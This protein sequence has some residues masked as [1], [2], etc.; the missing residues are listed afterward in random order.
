MVGPAGCLALAT[1]VRCDGLDRIGAMN[2]Q[3]ERLVVLAGRAP[4]GDEVLGPWGARGRVAVPVA[5]LS[6]PGMVDLGQDRLESGLCP[7][8]ITAP[9]ARGGVRVGYLDGIAYGDAAAVPPSQ[10][11]PSGLAG[12]SCRRTRGDHLL[13]LRVH[14]DGQ[15][16][17]PRLIVQ[18][19]PSQRSPVRPVLR[20]A[21]PGPCGLRRV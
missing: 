3:H 17:L 15:L 21:L 10:Q 1:V 11:E 8:L 4:D 19:G 13:R 5:D 14:F 20:A 6:E 16:G 12:P 2:E 9:G 18:A 7:E